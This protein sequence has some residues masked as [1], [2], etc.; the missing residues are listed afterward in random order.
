M[1]DL[2]RPA[3]LPPRDE[4]LDAPRGRR[5]AGL[6]LNG[7][8]RQGCFAM[9]VRGGGGKLKVFISWS[10]DRSKALAQAIH[11]WL[12]LVLHYV[13]P[14]LSQSDIDAG[15]RWSVEVAKELSAC[16]FGITCVTRE[17]Y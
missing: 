16:T 15:E 3:R 11:G 4:W 13:E 10:G 8:V 1:T 7:C 14:W 6:P 17:K 2:S 5:E 12:P 9:L